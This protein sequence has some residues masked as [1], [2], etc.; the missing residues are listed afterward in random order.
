MFV[1]SYKEC[2]V[3][4]L[5]REREYNVPNEKVVVVVVV[6]IDPKISNTLFKL[7]LLT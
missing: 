6:P 3:V 7:L 2:I 1:S 5:Q 4:R